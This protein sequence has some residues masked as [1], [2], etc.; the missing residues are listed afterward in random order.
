MTGWGP[1]DFLVELIRNRPLRFSLA[2]LTLYWV[3]CLIGL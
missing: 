2:C 1:F 3:T